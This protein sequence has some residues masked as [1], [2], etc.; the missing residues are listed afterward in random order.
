MHL[1]SSSAIFLLATCAYLG[2]RS[3]F[4]RKISGATGAVSK[5]DKAD[6]ALVGL[7]VV[8]QLLLPLLAIFSPLLDWATYRMPAPALAWAGALLM[9]AGVW[10]FWRSHADLGQNWSVT[11]EVQHERKLIS[12]G[13]YRAIRHP[14]YA[15]FF[16]MAVGQL[17][18]LPNWIAGPSA[19]LAVALLY[20]VRRPNEEAMMLEQFGDEYRSYMNATGGVFPRIG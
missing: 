5:G 17:L 14:M 20:L 8:G 18:L 2:V 16:M 19:L 9:A 7:V 10:L 12:H 1:T 15:S 11:L 6:M 3:Y 4:K 13:V